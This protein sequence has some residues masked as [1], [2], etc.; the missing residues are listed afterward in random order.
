[1]DDEIVTNELNM[2]TLVLANIAEITAATI[3]QINSSDI[4]TALNGETLSKEMLQQLTMSA[5]SA[6]IRQEGIPQL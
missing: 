3:R 5:L 4:S 1:M 6:A 2:S